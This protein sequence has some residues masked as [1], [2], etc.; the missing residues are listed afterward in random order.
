M[1]FLPEQRFGSQWPRSQQAALY[2]G[3]LVS[4]PFSSRRVGGGRWE[5][6][7]EEEPRWKLSFLWRTIVA[8]VERF[9]VTGSLQGGSKVRGM[10]SSYRLLL[11]GEFCNEAFRGEDSV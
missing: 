7:L 2:C 8:E 11:G 3:L 9:S 6:F 1:S 4:R 5:D 10:D